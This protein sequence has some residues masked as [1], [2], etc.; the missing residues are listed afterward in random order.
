MGRGFVI[1]LVTGEL[2]AGRT[3]A[4]E[5]FLVGEPGEQESLAFTTPGAVFLSVE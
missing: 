4:A 5:N 3:H 1:L 2:G